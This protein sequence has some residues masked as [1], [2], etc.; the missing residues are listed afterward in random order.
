METKHAP[1]HRFIQ[2]YFF[3]KHYSCYGSEDSYRHMQKNLKSKYIGFTKLYLILTDQ[4]CIPRSLFL[5]YTHRRARSRAHP[6]PSLAHPPPPPPPRP[7]YQLLLSI[8]A[9]PVRT[10]MSTI[11]RYT[12]LKS[13]SVYR[14]LSGLIKHEKYSSRIVGLKYDDFI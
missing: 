3:F 5:S 4:K 13:R 8:S 1:L 6:S 7:I 14:P 11:F 9:F 12:F 10:I 2:I